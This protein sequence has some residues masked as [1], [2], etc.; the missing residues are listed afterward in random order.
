MKGAAGR[1]VVSTQLMMP[2]NSLVTFS[3]SKHVALPGIKP[4]KSQEGQ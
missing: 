2:S 3:P 1:Y 4:A